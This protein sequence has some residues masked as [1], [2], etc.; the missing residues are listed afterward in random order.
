MKVYNNNIYVYLIKVFSQES[1]REDFINGKLFLNEAG[2]F[3]KLDNTYRGDK[4][5][6]KIIEKNA[7]IYINRDKFYPSLITYGFVGDDKVPILCCTILNEK[8]LFVKDFK[9]LKLRKEVIDELSKFGKY[10]LI[11][12][13]GEIKNNIDKVCKEKNILVDQDVVKYVDFEDPNKEYLKIYMGDP[14]KR[15]FVKNISYKYQNELRFIFLSNKKDKFVP[16]I[17]NTENHYILQLPKLSWYMKFDMTT[18]VDF[19]ISK[20]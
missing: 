6:S 8:S 12:Y 19:K 18:G 16:L 1:Y 9:T 15:Y 11:F 20:G 5:D 17:R 13:Y 3:N 14:Y 10:G 7:T 4:F 2:Y